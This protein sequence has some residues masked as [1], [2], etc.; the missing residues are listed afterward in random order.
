MTDA[1]QIAEIMEQLASGG[2]DAT[3][4]EVDSRDTTWT[5]FGM[6]CGIAERLAKRVEELERFVNGALLH[7]L[8]DI[9]RAAFA[10]ELG[11]RY[12]EAIRSD[13]AGS[14]ARLEQAC[15]A[16]LDGKPQP[17]LPPV[18]LSL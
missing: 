9:R 17:E 11:V 14:C 15:H 5:D 6:V 7:S 12:T 13:V 2:Y 8:L 4:G 18:Q 3:E 1:E 16:I 10:P